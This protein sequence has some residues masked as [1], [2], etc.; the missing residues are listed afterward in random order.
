V[1]PTG[2][3]P[4]EVIRAIPVKDRWYGLSFYDLLSNEHNFVDLQKTRLNYRS[5]LNS[6]VYFLD[7]NSVA[8][9]DAGWQFD[10]QLNHVWNAKNREGRADAPLKVVEMPKMDEQIWMLVEA[11]IQNARLASG[12]ITPADAAAADLNESKTLGQT[13]LLNAESELMSGN[14]DQDVSLGIIKTLK[15]SIVCCF[16]DATI[17]EHKAAMQADMNE[18]LSSTNGEVLMKWLE[19]NAPRKLLNTVRLLMTK[20]RNR[21]QMQAN[22]QAR[23]LLVGE[24]TW[25]EI[26]ALGPVY[27]DRFRS[28]YEGILNNLDVPNAANLVKTP[29]PVLLPP[30]PGVPGQE[31]APGAVPG[32][33]AVP[34]ITPAQPD[35]SIKKAA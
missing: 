9:V 25:L 4:F 16:A 6:A 8:E 17:A 1:S 19:N 31:Q 20:Q 27:A 13:Q 28:L 14:T 12:T 34:P 7:E 5:A 23:A 10:L 11:A 26:E 24:M 22:E 35:T 3:R 30:V 15:Q 29:M 18:I 32:V 21:E 2:K 33:P